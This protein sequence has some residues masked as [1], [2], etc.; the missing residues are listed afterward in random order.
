[1]R[2][3]YSV[4]RLTPC[5]TT[6]LGYRNPVF[7]SIV[8][9][10]KINYTKGIRVLFEGTYNAGDTL[11]EIHVPRQLHTSSRSIYLFIYLF[12]VILNHN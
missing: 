11:L 5:K 3:T 9:S 12:I 6:R 4:L 1:M 2:K 8:T 10:W 7:R